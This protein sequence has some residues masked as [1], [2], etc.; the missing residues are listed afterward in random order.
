MSVIAYQQQAQIDN[1]P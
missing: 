1:R